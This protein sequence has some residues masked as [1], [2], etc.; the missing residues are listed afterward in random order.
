[1]TMT[2]FT[3]RKINTVNILANDTVMPVS[4]RAYTI[5][6]LSDHTRI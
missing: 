4:N 6:P 1:M 2:V 5:I 3:G